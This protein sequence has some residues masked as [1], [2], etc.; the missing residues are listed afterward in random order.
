MVCDEERTLTVAP[1]KVDLAAQQRPDLP[2]VAAVVSP[3]FVAPRLKT[4]GRL[5]QKTHRRQKTYARA[6]STYGTDSE[7]EDRLEESRRRFF[8]VWL[9]SMVTF[10]SVLIPLA[11]VLIPLWPARHRSPLEPQ[12]TLAPDMAHEDPLKDSQLSYQE[13][14]AQKLH[15]DN[16]TALG[17][18]S[19]HFQSRGRSFQYRE[20]FCI[21]DTK[22]YRP[23]AVY[24]ADHVPHEFCSS[25]VHSSLAVFHDRAQWKRPDVDA[26]FAE[27]LAGQQR[28]VQ[29]RG[30]PMP[31]YA[32]L[33]GEA[34][35]NAN[36]T[37]VLRNEER[38]KRFSH[39]LTELL[40]DIRYKGLHVDWN[41][42]QGLCGDRTDTENL[43]KF[44]RTLHGMAKKGVL[45]LLSVP[46]NLRRLRHYGLEQL[47]P[48]LN[49]VVVATHRLRPRPAV[50]GCWG[51]GVDAAR[52]MRAVRAEFTQEWERHFGYS[53]SVGAH[54]FT[55]EGS[56][57]LGAPS[58]APSSF[59]Y[60]TRQP[61][62]TRYDF[63]CGLP[64]AEQGADPECAIGYTMDA[65]VAT[66]G[67][68]DMKHLEE[69][70]SHL[71]DD[72]NNHSWLNTDTLERFSQ[73]IMCPNG[74][75]CQ[76]DGS[77]RGSKHDAG[78]FRKTDVY[79]KLTSL[80]KGPSYCVYGDPAYPFRPLLMNPY[81]GA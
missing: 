17:K 74:I 13:F 49:L 15:I 65:S 38:L 51:R 79:T 72:V 43:L 40:A 8:F 81:G 73:A 56:A 52:V 14:C 57:R 37:K 5:A 21:L 12:Q 23:D 35:D 48:H 20:I 75:I 80:V 33:G 69:K 4:G 6:R 55:T 78:N 66:S 9:L 71:L 58:K 70:F 47:L 28:S 29:H 34:E 25:I 63:V 45:L 42:P 1:N 61:G 24:H 30:K 19:S 50:V 26:D 44:V 76:L 36:F 60:Y 53:V 22:Y 2:S 64:R 18:A 46:P 54:T 31:V 62:K 27:R 16:N 3:V 11:L 32:T 67:R 41:H 7:E 10:V 59:D 39:Q 77:Y 68:Q